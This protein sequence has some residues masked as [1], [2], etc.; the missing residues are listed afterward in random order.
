MAGPYPSRTQTFAPGDQ[1]PSTTLNAVQDGI[2]GCSDA[3]EAIEDDE[4]PLKLESTTASGN[5]SDS[6]A[7]NDT[8]ARKVWFE[9]STNGVTPVVLDLAPDW[10]QRFIRLVLYV[11]VSPNY[12][13][14]GSSDDLIEYVH[15]NGGGIVDTE[16][17]SGLFFSK[18]GSAG[19]GSHPYLE[20]TPQVG[21]WTSEKVRIFVRTD[22][23]LCMRKDAHAV[24]T[25]IWV[26][27]YAECS[28][29]QGH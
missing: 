4:L 13:P 8:G 14:G 22:G 12:M 6:P 23:V 17:V 5:H 10:R 29:K 21:S 16:S 2:V 11:N 28:P 24:D 19:G 27:G 20:F 15:V 9:K 25:D 3:I 26:V 7:P 18:D 1:V